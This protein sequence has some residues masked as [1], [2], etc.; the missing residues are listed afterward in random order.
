MAPDDP[1]ITLPYTLRR[2]APDV[3]RFDVQTVLAYIG[4]QVAEA[5]G[6]PP[7][8]DRLLERLALWEGLLRECRQLLLRGGSGV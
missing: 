8:H 2:P 7:S 1:S 6:E 3:M 5:C 4:R